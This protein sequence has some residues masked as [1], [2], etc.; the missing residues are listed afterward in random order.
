[1]NVNQHKQRSSLIDERLRFENIHFMSDPQNDKLVVDNRYSKSASVTFLSRYRERR[2][3]KREN[4]AT[5]APRV[6][7][8]TH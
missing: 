2:L 8:C 3:Q 5:C 6:T 4:S 7:F 1:M